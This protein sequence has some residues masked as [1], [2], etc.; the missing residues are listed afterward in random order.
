MGADPIPF[1]GM[2]IFPVDLE[3]DRGMVVVRKHANDLS[4]ME[5]ALITYSQFEKLLAFAGDS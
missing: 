4:P 5:D 3:P 1:E 2:A